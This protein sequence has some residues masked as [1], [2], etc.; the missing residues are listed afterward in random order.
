MPKTRHDPVEYV[1]KAYFN[2]NKDRSSFLR[3]APLY[4]PH[5]MYVGNDFFRFTCVCP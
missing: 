2:F 3:F 1:S 5:C 4:F